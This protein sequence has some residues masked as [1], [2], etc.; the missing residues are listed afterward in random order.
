MS[1]SG[2]VESLRDTKGIRNEILARRIEKHDNCSICNRQTALESRK[3]KKR[4]YHLFLKLIDSDS[5][6]RLL[7]IDGKI[8]MLTSTILGR[9][10]WWRSGDDFML[11]DNFQN[12][13]DPEFRSFDTYRVIRTESGY[14]PSSSST[15][16]NAYFAGIHLAELQF[17]EKNKN[18]LD[19]LHRTL[20]QKEIIMSGVFTTKNPDDYNLACAICKYLGYSKEKKL[21]KRYH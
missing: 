15:P 20:G 3:I 6:K 4:A 21:S 12:M 9:T 11:Q 2:L 10:G 1:Q 5:K 18:E 8:S 13:H 16:Y 7:D 14:E 19:E 17:V